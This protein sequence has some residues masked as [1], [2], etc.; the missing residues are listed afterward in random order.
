MKSQEGFPQNTSEQENP[1][2]EDREYLASTF[3]NAA[4]KA[5]ARMIEIQQKLR[6]DV[7]LSESER[8]NLETELAQVAEEMESSNKIASEHIT[9]PNN[10]NVVDISETDVSEG[11]T[12]DMIQD[13]RDAA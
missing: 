13:T 9:F 2:P 11:F 7:S 10:S 12:G 5:Y 8:K 6:Y 3:Q 1:S 4:G